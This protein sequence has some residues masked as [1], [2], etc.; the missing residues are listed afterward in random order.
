MTYIDDQWPT[1][2]NNSVKNSDI[3]VLEN[4]QETI[5]GRYDRQHLKGDA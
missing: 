1:L 4:A 3:F 2:I 5:L